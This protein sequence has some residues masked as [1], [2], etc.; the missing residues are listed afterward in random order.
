MESR[1]FV[2]LN[3]NPCKMC[4]PIGAVLAYKGIENSMIILHGSQ[5]CTAYMRTHMSGH[6]NEPIDIASSSLNE[7]GTV[8]GGEHNLKKG[9]RNVIKVYNPEI[10]GVTTTCLSE[11][12]GEDIKRI[13]SEFIFEEKL[14]DVKIVPNHSPG[15]G[16]TQFEGY[17]SAL[18]AI[19]MELGSDARANRK[20]NIIAANMSPGDIRNIKE[21]L[22]EF[23]LDYIM[24][25]DVSDTLDAPFSREFLR[26][27][28]GGTKLRD[29]KMM[30]GAA[31]TIEIGATV[32]EV[33]SPGEYLHSK[34]GVPLYRCGVPIGLVNTD[35]FVKILKEITGRSIPKKL[36]EQRGRLIDGMVDSHKHNA[37]GRA[38]IYGE[39]EIV[40]GVSSLCFENGIKPVIISTGAQSSKLFELLGDRITNAEEKP[41]LLED[42]DFDTIEKYTISTNGNLM[43]GSSDGKFI[44]EKLGIPAVRIGFPIHDRVGG[45][46]L[47]YT[48]YNGSLK[49]LD[50]ITNTLLINK[51]GKHRKQLYNELYK[52]EELII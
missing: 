6:Y 28:K 46:R 9:L 5:G 42:T 10:I 48:G 41:V 47:V 26:I 34:F 17:F 40:Y 14:K 30:P 22:E 52:P 45:Q 21:I 3:V 35:K 50:D 44:T 16:G 15:Y 29:I 49:L 33:I 12:I 11:T 23:E 4:M 32:P 7:Q 18:K 39:P 36:K 19:V 43:I 1:N 8:Y 51:Y 31:A 13:T 38:V 24:L 20:V 37:M 25:P 27:P 2:N